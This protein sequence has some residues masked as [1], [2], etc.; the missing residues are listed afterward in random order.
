[1]MSYQLTDYDKKIFII[2]SIV[3]I[4]TFFYD[5][6]Y[7]DVAV[8]LKNT[9]QHHKHAVIIITLI[10]H[11]MSVFGLFGWLFNNKI[12]LFLYI[13]SVIIT[14]LQWKLTG[15][16]CIVTKSVAILSDTSEYRRFNDVY[17]ILNIKKYIRPK[18]LY[19]GSLSVFIT[20][21]LYKLFS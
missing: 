4:T 7:S 20:I 12:L 21:A 6:I 9:E 8:C 17:K 11:F 13:S 5:V 10:H 1:M 2:L 3:A 18:L 16:E 19:Y 14:V 15:G